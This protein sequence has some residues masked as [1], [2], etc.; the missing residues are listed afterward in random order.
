L[1][2][3]GSAD[4]WDSHWS[5]YGDANQLNPAQEFRRNLAL[6]LVGGDGAPARLLDIGSG[7]GAFLADAVARWPQIELLG[8]ELSEAAVTAAAASVPRARFE[9]RDLTVE[10]AAGDHAGWA[11][12][13]VCSEVLEHVDEPAAVLRNARTW[14]AP[15]C[16]VIVTVPGGPMSAFDRHIGHRRHFTADDLRGVLR[17]AG[18]EV[19]EIHGA[20]FPFFNLYRALVIVRGERLV[21]DAA[22]REA[23]GRAKLAA[24]LLLAMFK[25]LLRM[26][27][28]HSRYG[29]QMVAVAHEPRGPER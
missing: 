5:D 16:R 8:L 15:G 27:V 14:L 2:A 19:A 11:T 1:S 3:A 4:A 25:P 12:H 21:S 23:S 9:A 28:P 17:A 29:W 18:L 22:V 10:R 24:R 6:K 20:G 26:T 13:A 7:T